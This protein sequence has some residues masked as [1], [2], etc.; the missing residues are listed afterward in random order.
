[1][2]LEN[3]VNGLFV[4]PLDGNYLESFEPATGCPFGQVPDSDSRDVESAV[5]AATEAFPIWSRTSHR[6]RASI[7]N[8]I[9]DL[10]ESRLADFAAAESRDQGK[11]ISLAS[12]VDIPR[13]VHNFRYFANRLAYVE[14]K[15]VDVDTPMGQALCYTE[16]MPIGVAGLIA[17]WN[18]PLYLLTWK[19]APC[20]AA[21]NTCVCKPSE[22]TSVTAWMLCSLFQE[23][24]LPA[25]VVNMVFGT[26]PKAGAAIVQHPRIPLISFTGGTATGERVLKDSAPFYKKVSLELGG[27]NANIIFE[28]ANLERCIATTVRSSFANQ[29]EICLCGSRI[30]V[31]RGLYDKFMAGFLHQVSQLHPADPRH[32][33]TRLGALVSREHLDKVLGYVKLA[34]D[35]GCQVLAGPRVE[36]AVKSLVDPPVDLSKGYFMEPTVIAASSPQVDPDKCRV[37]QEEI[38]GPVVTVTAFDTEDQVINWANGTQYGLSASVW[39]ENGSRQRRIAKAL[40][41]GTVWINCWMVRDLNLPFGGMKNSGIGREGG[42]YSWDFYTEAKAV[43]LL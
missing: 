23:A 30:F 15:K 4:A 27:K 31:Q 38:F 25:G 32:P 6:Q 9:A 7:M 19:I 24:G 20:I 37:M 13:A 2:K 5:V 26:G 8:R 40:R 28:D 17:P 29:G 14:D 41:V 11:P 16:R 39:T 42:E 22:L 33:E 18:L 36:T 21:G 1:M 35:E 10:L 43:C 12:A 34:T 3:F